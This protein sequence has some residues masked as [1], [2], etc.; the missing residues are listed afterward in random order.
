[1]PRILRPSRQGLGAQPRQPGD[2]TLLAGRVVCRQHPQPRGHENGAGVHA[3]VEQAV[4]DPATQRVGRGVA[5]RTQRGLGPV[6]LTAEHACARHQAGEVPFDGGGDGVFPVTPAHAGG[7]VK[8]V[9][10]MRITVHDLVGCLVG[11]QRGATGL[12][13]LGHQM[14]VGA[15]HALQHL[16]QREQP[17]DFVEH[18]QH[19]HRAVVSAQRG[20]ATQQRLGGLIG[21][22]HGGAHLDLRPQADHEA[23]HL[24][25]ARQVG[26]TRRQHRG[27]RRA[28]MGGQGHLAA[29]AIG[30]AAQHSRAGGHPG[31][32][33]QWRER[34]RQIRI[35]ADD[36]RQDRPEPKPAAQRSARAEHGQFQFACHAPDDRSDAGQRG[37]RGALDNDDKHVISAIA[38]V[39]HTAE[40][41]PRVTALGG[42]TAA[43]VW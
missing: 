11:L 7:G 26:R 34:H 2:Q 3:H 25:R 14:A 40:A 16:R 18:A 1:M 42:P 33:G 13:V 27:A 21:G 37:G 35:A 19:R 22:G 24:V 17:G 23:I 38:C 36:L 15:R 20:M 28:Q 4:V 43:G 30:G 10:E 29:R 39:L 8:H 41:P 6:H 31:H 32:D 12:R 9:V 5:I